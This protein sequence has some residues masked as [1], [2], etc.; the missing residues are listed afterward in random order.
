MVGA[1]V[2]A[3]ATL[4]VV[5]AA[6][7]GGS[8]AEIAIA[9]RDANEVPDGW[10]RGRAR[11]RYP[12]RDASGLGRLRLR[13]HAGRR[14]THRHRHRA[15]RLAVRSST[16]CTSEAGQIPT[17]P[18]TWVSLWE[19]PS[20]SGPQVVGP[21]GGETLGVNDR[22]ADFRTTGLSG[23]CRDAGDAEQSDLGAAFEIEAF[24]DHGRVFVARVVTVYPASSDAGDQ[25]QARLDELQSQIDALAVQIAASPP[26][27]DVL[28][29]QLAALKNQ[30]AAESNAGTPDGAAPGLLL[31]NQ[32]LNSL[33]IAPLEP[34][35]TVTAIPATTLPPTIALPLP[36]TT[37]PPFVPATTDEQ[38]ITSRFVSW[39][40][41]HTDDEI[42]STFED[43]DSSSV[44]STRGWRSTASPTWP[45]TR[46]WST[47]S[48]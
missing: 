32:V 31:G 9:P 5:R 44:P 26:N 11:L 12:V 17:Q 37:A 46:A 8:S 43:A 48:A 42:R 4:G 39:L 3:V 18:G 27:V 36:A 2:V 23:S 6:D 33:R 38:E 45:S 1:L 15:G 41:V 20:S 14:A 25:L 16:R 28:Q 19:Y 30:L 34:A 35:T 47:R 10:S 40:R 13:Q 7:D 21:G 24:R 22:P 29:A